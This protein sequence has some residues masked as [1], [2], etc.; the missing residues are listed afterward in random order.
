MSEALI[1]NNRLVE[2]IS[3]HQVSATDLK[4]HNQ[5]H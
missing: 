3:S 4:I 1:L 2:N 5:M